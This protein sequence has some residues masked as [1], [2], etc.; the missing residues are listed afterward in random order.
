MDSGQGRR[1]RT[2]AGGVG[3]VRCAKFWF[4]VEPATNADAPRPGSSPIPLTAS[5]NTSSLP[6]IR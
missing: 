2:A 5:R 4:P 1:L 3:A 6:W